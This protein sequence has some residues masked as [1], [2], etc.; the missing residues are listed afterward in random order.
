MDLNKHLEFFDPNKIKGAIHIIG[1]GAIGS[2]VAEMLA[3]I[4]VP[5]LFIYDIDTVSP[6]NITNQMYRTNQIGMDKV[7]ALEIL[8][9]EINPDISI[10]K[11]PEG[12]VDHM[13]LSGNVVLAVDNIEL[14]RKIVEQ[15]M[16]NPVIR[17]F[18]DFRMRLTD[19]QHYAAD[20]SDA[21]Q[22][23]TFYYSMN[24][25]S[26][27]AKAA[28]PVSVC[29]TSLSITP[30]VRMIVSLGVANMIHFF[31]EEPITKVMAADAFTCEILTM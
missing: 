9:K 6:H 22:K 23:E 4:G 7:D 2:T 14:R 19:A 10:I 16:Y 20:W 5:E 21:K 11:H 18:Y 29:G 30:T 12:Y 24:F 28:T 8:L 17:S 1:V 15:N 3:R 26:E 13:P 27:E 25:S 31:K